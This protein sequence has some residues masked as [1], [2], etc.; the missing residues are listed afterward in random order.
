MPPELTLE[1][2]A[3]LALH[4][5]QRQKLVEMKKEMERQIDAETTAIADELASRG[6]DTLQLDDWTVR[7]QVRE[8]KTLD[9]TAL[10]NLGVSTETITQATKTSTYTQLDVRKRG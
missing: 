5:E 4:V 2:T 7:L 3:S 10:V 1:Q 9:K 8:R 6:L